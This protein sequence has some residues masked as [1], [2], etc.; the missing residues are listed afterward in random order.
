MGKSLR[1]FLAV[2]LTVGMIA[3]LC[4]VPMTVSAVPADETYEAYDVVTYRD[5][6]SGGNP[7]SAAKTSL[8]GNPKFAYNHTSPS[9]SVILKYRWT[10]GADPHFVFFFDAWGGSAYPFALAVKRP[11]FGDLGAASGPNGAWHLDPSKNDHIVQMTE[12]IVEGQDYDIEHARLKVATGENAG[13]YYVYVKV[14]GELIYGYYYDG[15]NS[16]GTYGSGGTLSDNY[17][18][19]TGSSADNYISATPVPD[20]YDDYDEV[21]YYDFLKND[22]LLYNSNPNEYSISDD[23]FTYNKTSEY[24]SAVIK[25]RWKGANTGSS[26]YISFDPPPKTSDP[27]KPAAEYTFGVLYSGSSG[28]IWLRIGNGSSKALSEPL[29]MGNDYDIEYGRLKIIGGD[30][31]GKYKLY[32]RITDVA[33]GNEMYYEEK[34]IEASVVNAG[35]QYTSNTD[36]AGSGVTCTIS[37]SFKINFWGNGGGNKIAPIPVP[38]TYEA[39]DEITYNDLLSGGNP[40]TAEKT[41]MSGNPRFAYNC[42]SPTYSL[43]FKYRWTAG[44]DP[45]YVFYFDSWSGNSYPFCLAVKRPNFGGLGAAAGANG[46]WHLDPSEASHIVQMDTPIVT[47][48]NYDIE[49]ARLMVATGPNAGKYYVYVKVNGVLIYD[50]YYD[51]A[52]GDGTYGS[53]SKVQAFDPTYLRFTSGSADSYIS[54]T[55]EPETYDA[56]D[57]VDYEDFLKDGAPLASEYS[58][59][60]NKFTYNKTSASG[61][62][63]IRYRW[64]G[65]NTGSSFYISFDPPPKTSDPHQPAAEYTFGV[66][67]SGSA[68]TIWLRIGNGSSKAISP[69]LT[70]GK[71]YDIECARLK[72]TGGPN[73]GAYKFWIKITDGVTGEEAYYEEKY[74]EKNVVNADG[75]YTSNTDGAGS[76]VTCTISN[77]FYISFWGNGGGNKITASPVIGDIDGN[78][79]VNELDLTALRNILT[80]SELSPGYVADFNRDTYINICDYVSMKVY[81]VV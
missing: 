55:P 41:S 62:A 38:E 16:D 10:A 31:A 44:S 53:G 8:S 2:I 19:F 37:N 56:Y 26:F 74:I 61:S 42:T 5:L 65:A 54:A 71:D 78:G 81:I 73:K 64:K 25:Y 69:A 43:I 36:G 3:T 51:G 27:S 72:V 23:K 9:Y 20:V 50:Y 63:I 21:T 24:G 67:Y 45:H 80:E 52:N 76:G 47:G 33:T 17:L 57:E 11:N 1:K 46:A 32:I 70:M 77:S 35:G 22:T 40:V 39:Y 14:N 79:I 48:Q 58:I 4:A 66:L 7:L 13:K 29:T 15:V 18:R 30:H 59:N 28:T 60:S 49:H 68:S 12:P 6:L 34:Y 75:Q